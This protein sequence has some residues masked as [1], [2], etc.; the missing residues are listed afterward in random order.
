MAHWGSAG[1][2][3]PLLPVEHPSGTGG[4]RPVQNLPCAKS[5]PPPRAEGM[6]RGRGDRDPHPLRLP[7]LSSILGCHR[8]KQARGGLQ[9]GEGH[10]CALIE[11]GRRRSSPRCVPKSS[12]E[13]PVAA[14]Q[15]T[16]GPYTTSTASCRAL[17]CPCSSHQKPASQKPACISVAFRFSE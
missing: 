1:T 3:W 4:A 5:A 12:G 9:H 8:H 2:W 15:G 10:R 6:L 11:G 17:A 14:P 16:A 13:R 7:S